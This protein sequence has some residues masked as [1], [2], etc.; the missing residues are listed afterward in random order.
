MACAENTRSPS[1]AA[2]RHSREPLLQLVEGILGGRQGPWVDSV[3]AHQGRTMGCCAAKY[4]VCRTA[5]A[6]PERLTGPSL[7]SRNHRSTSC[8]V[9]SSIA[10]TRDAS[11]AVVRLCP[12]GARVVFSQTF[13]E[14]RRVRY[15]E[16]STPA[17]GTEISGWSTLLR[18][19]QRPI[20]GQCV[21]PISCT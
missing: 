6:L 13:H 5:L 7:P 11:S 10:S 15:V 8:G 3:F 18:N 17:T 19:S 20:C 12:A 14:W 16:R 2:A 1:C 9:S 21:R 4:C